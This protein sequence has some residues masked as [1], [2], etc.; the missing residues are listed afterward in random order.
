MRQESENPR[1]LL[2]NAVRIWGGGERF[3]LDAAGGLRDR[4]WPVWI[5]AQP[6]SPLARRAQEAGIAVHEVATRANG[7]PW[8]VLPLSR[9]LHRNRIDIVLTNFD[10]DLRTTGLAAA[11]CPRPIRL[12]HS[13]ECDESLKA[14]W[15]LPHLY[16][17]LAHALLFNSQATRRTVLGS[18]PRLAELPHRILHKGVRL[19]STAA[20]PSPAVPRTLGFLGQL[21]ARKDLP[22][23]LRALSRLDPGRA[24]WR[25]RVAG[26][27]PLRRRW[28]AMA[29][30][31]GLGETVHFE[32]FVSDPSAWLEEIDLLVHPAYREGWGYAPIEALAHG[33]HVVARRASS[34]EELL[35][36]APAAHLFEDEDE[37]LDLL[38][39]L[40]GL[41]RTTWI[42]EGTL[43]RDF[44]AQHYGIDRM[45]AELETLLKRW[46]P[47]P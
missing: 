1:L 47:R 13:F 11:L 32:G 28:E 16:T 36:D 23:L 3:L 31:L 7:A 35:A 33:R 6:H 30:D 22:I 21:V 40:A 26:E 12:V 39:Q 44:V 18:A 24:P 27:G 10:R 43:A 8:T 20:R 41:S 42:A 29:R 38:Q 9:W 15:Y 14:R 5:Q 17:G 46:A 4:G 2:A 34:L 25:L 19:P 45:I 37:L